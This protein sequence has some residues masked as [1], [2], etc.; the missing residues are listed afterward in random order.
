MA[1]LRDFLA[2]KGPQALLWIQPEATV[3]DAAE[4]MDRHR[5]GSLLVLSDAQVVGIVTERDI[6]VRVVVPGL[7]PHRTAVRDIATTEVICC[8]L[9]TGLE[10]ARGIRKTCRIRHL[11]VLD[12]QQ[13]LH[14]IVSIGD[15]NAYEAHDREVTI[16][17]L[18]EYIS[19]HA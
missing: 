4:L 15:L 12:E 13:R 17:V 2:A 1:T 18:E 6:L 19:G 8:R 9:H 7:D 11:P 5:V 16:H 14:G 10:E 3:H